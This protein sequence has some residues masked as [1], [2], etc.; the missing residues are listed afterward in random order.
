MTTNGTVG[1][2]LLAN[3]GHGVIARTCTACKANLARQKRREYHIGKGDLV[4]CDGETMLATVSRV[5]RHKALVCFP[6]RHFAWCGL[7]ELTRIGRA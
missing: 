2:A 6:L 7:G 5:T 4:R 3:C 1:A